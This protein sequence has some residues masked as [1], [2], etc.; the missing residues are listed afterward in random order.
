MNMKNVKIW[1]WIQNNRVLKAV[2]HPDSGTLI[3]YD[4]YDNILLK[5]TGLS[6]QQIKKIE[7]ILSSFSGRK[8]GENKESFIC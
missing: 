6:K 1:I 5:R 3:I 8:V 2:S 7:L 4:E